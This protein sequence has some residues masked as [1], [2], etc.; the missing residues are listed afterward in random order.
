MHG[1]Y[2]NWNRFC[3]M[4]IDVGLDEVIRGVVCQFVFL[5]YID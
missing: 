1:Y 2:A 3:D 4:K 5:S